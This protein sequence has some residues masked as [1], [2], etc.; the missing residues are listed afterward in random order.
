MNKKKRKKETA[1]VENML[2]H[3][4]ANLKCVTSMKRCKIGKV[5]DVAGHM[6]SRSQ[7]KKPLSCRH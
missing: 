3:S 7:I 5:V 6:V 4:T 2:T 1:N